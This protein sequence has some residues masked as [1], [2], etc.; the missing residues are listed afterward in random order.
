MCSTQVRFNHWIVGEKQ[1][2][3]RVQV[4]KSESES[5]SSPLSPSPSHHLKV[6]VRV[7]TSKSE[8]ESKKNLSPSHVS[9]CSSPHYST[10]VYLP[11][12]E[13]KQQNVSNVRVNSATRHGRYCLDSGVT[14]ARVT[15]SE[16]ESESES[17]RKKLDSNP[18]PSKMDSSPSPYSSHTA[19]VKKPAY[20]VSLKPVV[21]VLQILLKFFCKLCHHKQYAVLMK[22]INTSKS[23]RHH[24][25][26]K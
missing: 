26:L 19:L 24:L 2:C 16:S 22:W 20:C 11:K 18:S 4:V 14:R 15:I 13:N 25:S 7:I 17:K 8:S 23:L 3:V 5:E 12:H 1:C 10:F 6:R 9:T 21:C